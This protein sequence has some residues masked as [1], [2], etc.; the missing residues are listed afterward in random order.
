MV[1]KYVILACSND[2]KLG[3]P[4]Q[5]VDINGEPVIARTIRQLKEHGIDD[6]IVV[7]KDKRF[8]ELG[9][10]VHKPLNSTYNY[11]TEE[12]YYIDLFPFELMNEPV[13]FMMGDVYFSDDAI[14]TIVTTDT[15][16]T[17]YFCSYNNKANEYIK[18]WDE[19]FAY[20]VVDIELFKNKINEVKRLWDEKATW[21]NPIIWELYR[22]INGLN[23]NVHKMTENYIAINDVT[24]D[25]DDKQDADLLRLRTKTNMSKKLT[26]VIPYYKTIQYTIPLLE[27]LIP[28]LTD[29]TEVYLIDDGCNEKKLDK[30]KDKINIIHLK[31]NKGG[32]FA[33]NEG[34]R[35]SDGKYIAIVDSDDMISDDYILTL[36]DA[37]DNTSKDVIVFDWEDMHSHCRVRHPQNYAPWKAIYKRQIIPLFP[38]GR[39][40]SYDV[41][42]YDEIVAKRYDTY[43]INK[44]LYYYNSNREGS[45]TQE[46]AKKIKEGEND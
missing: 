39:T 6:I 15:D 29:D 24:C 28:Q 34:I 3:M 20:K 10:K 38:E 22:C 19:P 13:C 35:K 14:N 2:D 12:G 5:L 30:Y 31:E 11:L 32:A 33:T 27:K 8:N 46:K 17:L 44:V 41:P 43:Y 26:I 36:I 23:V 40:Y 45:L 1:T 42:F 18:K 37:I 7:A 16:S 21:R 9:V 4:R 25:I